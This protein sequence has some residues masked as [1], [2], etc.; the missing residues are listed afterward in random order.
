MKKVFIESKKIEIVK[1]NQSHW[2]QD[3]ILSDISTTFFIFYFF[4][5]KFIVLGRVDLHGTQYMQ[6]GSK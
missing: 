3:S 2:F 1:E 5:V 6:T 4:C